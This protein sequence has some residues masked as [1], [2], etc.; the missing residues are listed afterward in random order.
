MSRSKERQR[1]TYP[2]GR[3]G[4]F[5]RRKEEEGRDSLS[6]RSN[7]IVDVLLFGSASCNV[8]VEGNHLAI[9]T[10]R[11]FKHQELAELLLV[12]LIC[13]NSFLDKGMELFVPLG[14]LRRFSLK[15]F[16]QISQDLI[17][18]LQREELW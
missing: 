6:V 4:E 9:Q 11:G 18:K 13:A 14:V 15:S 3:R 16:G 17:P 5:R 7:E 1:Q 8:L 12:S 10:S 2:K